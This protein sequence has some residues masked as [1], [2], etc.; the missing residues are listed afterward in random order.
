MKVNWI[1]I[2][3]HK[4]FCTITVLNEKGKLTSQRDI[5]TTEKD[6]I[7]S[8]STI[9]GIRNVVIEE[10]SIANWFFLTLNPYANKLVICDPKNNKWIH[11]SEEKDDKVDSVKLADLLRMNRIKPVYHTGLKDLTIIGKLVTH[12]NKLVQN[13][14]RAMNRIKGEYTFVGIFAAGKKVYSI[15]ERESYLKRIK[16]QHHKEI[17]KD[18]YCQYDLYKRQQIEI[19]KRLGVIS[20]R[21]PIIKKLSTI[22]GIGF[23]RAT[24]IYATIVTP[25]RFTTRS[26][27]NKYSGLSVVR[28][29]SSDKVLCTYASKTGNLV[30]K[31]VLMDASATCISKNNYFS[32]RYKELIKKGLCAKSAKRSIAR[33]IMHIAIGI[34]RNNKKFS[35]KIAIKNK[36]TTKKAA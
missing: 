36:R 23:I 8:I 34:W 31:S 35:E 28:K 6:L 15:K 32:E 16:S 33:E 2:D 3:A 13:S 7:E 18:Y 21:H 14:T 9:K 27:I 12:Y 26:Q 30:L 1:G 24:I 29:G 22:P 25:C 5:A 20:K 19:V 11:S 10:S 17:I 4:K